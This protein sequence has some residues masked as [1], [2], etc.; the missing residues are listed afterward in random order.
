MIP[1]DINPLLAQIAFMPI[2]SHW[3]DRTTAFSYDNSQV[4]AFILSIDQNL[5]TADAIY[6]YHVAAR[7][8]VMLFDPDS[9]TWIGNQIWKQ[10]VKKEKTAKTPTALFRDDEILN[11]ILATN[12]KTTSGICRAVCSE[13]H[14]SR[15]TF[16]R[17]FKRL[18][19]SGRLPT[20]NDS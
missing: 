10:P 11:L 12:A 6:I 9:K 7:K 20:K 18:Q 17:I 1:D 8:C 14:C 13:L 15:A 2:K 4:V 16:Y 19:K 3:P 5:S